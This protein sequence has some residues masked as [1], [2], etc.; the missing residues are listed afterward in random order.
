MG[1]NMNHDIPKKYWDD[2]DN[3]IHETEISLSDRVQDLLKDEP[4]IA[5]SALI[6]THC[7]L[8]ASCI[9]TYKTMYGITDIQALAMFFKQIEGMYNKASEEAE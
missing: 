3:I 1:I 5:L 4:N 9:K 2:L 7:A 8:M 6:M